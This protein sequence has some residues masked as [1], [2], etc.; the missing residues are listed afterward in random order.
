MLRVED[1]RKK[2]LEK[3]GQIEL[4]KQLKNFVQ[5]IIKYVNFLKRQNYARKQEEKNII[6]IK[7]LKKYY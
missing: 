2:H 3:L 7:M 6:K 4:L 5:I 1:L